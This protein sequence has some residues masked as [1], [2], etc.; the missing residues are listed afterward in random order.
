MEAVVLSTVWE[1]HGALAGAEFAISAGRGGTGAWVWVRPCVVWRMAAKG[2]AS[3]AW[4]TVTV[5][6]GSA[7]R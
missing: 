2:S 4:V 5:P 7:L 3:S 6:S 1:C